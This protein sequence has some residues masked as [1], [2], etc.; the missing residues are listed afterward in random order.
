MPEIRFRIR[1]PDGKVETCYSPSLVVKDFFSPGE[2][3]ALADFLQR[4][5]TAFGIASKR[6]EEKYG[7]PC[8]RAADQLDRIETAAQPFAG[9]PAARIAVDAFEE[10]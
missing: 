9:M 5:R 3:Y 10:E 1:W 6:V 7:F 4:S 2:T 8:S